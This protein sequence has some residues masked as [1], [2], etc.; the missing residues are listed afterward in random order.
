MAQ[1][2]TRDLEGLIEN[3]G[4]IGFEYSYFELRNKKS[5]R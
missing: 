1:Y 3:R 4:V 2:V 5:A